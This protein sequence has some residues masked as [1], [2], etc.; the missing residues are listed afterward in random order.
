MQWDHFLKLLW[1]YQH[2][3]LDIL[4]LGHTNFLRVSNFIVFIF[5]F[6]YLLRLNHNWSTCIDMV[7]LVLIQSSMLQI[8]A[9]LQK[10]V[11]IAILHPIFQISHLNIKM[12]FYLYLDSEVLISNH[13]KVWWCVLQ[14]HRPKRVTFLLQSIKHLDQKDVRIGVHEVKIFQKFLGASKTELFLSL[15][16]IF[17]MLMIH[18]NHKSH[19]CH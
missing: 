10:V 14:I 9:I 15:S 8:P 17:K 12:S 7:C 11:F 16:I 5:F 3:T 6:S 19:P 1:I 2:L 18:S 13:R 4:E